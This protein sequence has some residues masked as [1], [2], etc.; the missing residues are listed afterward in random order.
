VTQRILILGGD[1]YL[2]WPTAMA[3]SRAGHDVH[4]VDNFA[5]RQWEQEIGVR[6]L[7]AIPTLHER[8][9]AWREV[10]GSEWPASD[11][12]PFWSGGT[13]RPTVEAV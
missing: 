6:P 5:K 11:L 2:G 9:R 13:S 8:I 10:T 4:L 12:P 7:F 1:G 3:L